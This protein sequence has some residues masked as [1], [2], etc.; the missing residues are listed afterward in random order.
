MFFFF[1]FKHF[2]EARSISNDWRRMTFHTGGWQVVLTRNFKPTNWISKEYFLYRS[3]TQQW[4]YARVKA[5]GHCWGKTELGWAVSDSVIAGE[6]RNSTGQPRGLFPIHRNN[7]RNVEAMVLKWVITNSWN[8]RY[9]PSVT[10]HNT[11]ILNFK[12]VWVYTK[13]KT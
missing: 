9:R 7:S 2:L 13:K 6:W 10:S 12:E 5:V 4:L 11:G 8:P 1:H 3:K